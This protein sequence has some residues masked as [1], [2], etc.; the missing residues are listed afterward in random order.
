M[1][2]LYHQAPLIA[3][4]TVSMHCPQRMSRPPTRPQPA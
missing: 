3:A 4:L 1:R 2:L